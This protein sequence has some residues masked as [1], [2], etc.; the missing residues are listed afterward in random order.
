MIRRK[1]SQGDGSDW[2]LKNLGGPNVAGWGILAG[3][4][5]HR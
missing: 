2:F 4:A 1:K 5:F 3:E